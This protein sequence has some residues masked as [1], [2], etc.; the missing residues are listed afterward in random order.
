MS[1][2]FCR[3]FAM[4]GEFTQI[5]HFL[6]HMAFAE[7][8]CAL[9]ARMAHLARNPCAAQLAGPAHFMPIKRARMLRTASA[10]V[11]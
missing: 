10:L 3:F 2:W 8:P 5:S 7:K 9:A 6:A 4:S 1:E 11:P